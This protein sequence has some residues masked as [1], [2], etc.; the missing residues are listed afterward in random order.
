MHMHNV[1]INKVNFYKLTVAIYF[2]IAN[3]YSN[4]EKLSYSFPLLGMLTGSAGAS[5]NKM[6]FLI[7]IVLKQMI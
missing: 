5:K 4:S 6:T 7:K 1:L 3:E 2:V